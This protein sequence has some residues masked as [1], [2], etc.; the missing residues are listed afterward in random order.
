MDY[1]SLVN[2]LI[3]N[4]EKTIICIAKIMWKGTLSQESLQSC[5][6]LITAHDS[7]AIISCMSLSASN[8][9]KGE[10]CPTLLYNI[11]SVPWGLQVFI[12]AQLS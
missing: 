6:K 10:F 4:T 9:T 3:I 2:T 5:E 12:N 8:I 1:K 7:A 11:A